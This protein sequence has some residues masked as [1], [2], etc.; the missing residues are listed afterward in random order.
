MATSITIGDMHVLARKRGGKCLSKS[1]VN[2]H[3]KLLWKCGKCSYEWRTTPN[4]IKNKGRWCPLCGIKRRADK[5]R[6]TIADMRKLA[7]ERGGKCLSKTYENWRTNLIWQCAEGHVW[8]AAPNNVRRG[9][10]CR[11]CSS[12]L[13][14]RICR[15]F[16]EQLFN[17]P[18]PAKRPTW[19]LN[20]RGNRMELDGYCEKAGIAFE[21]Q[22]EQHY[23]KVHTFTKTT[24]QLT[25]RQE[26]DL[27]KQQICT[28]KGIALFVIRQLFLRIQPSQLKAF[29]KE[30]CLR[31]QVPLPRGFDSVT[32]NYSRAYSTNRERRALNEL[33]ELARSR[34]GLL[35][36]HTYM[37]A[38]RK[39]RWKCGKCSY[40]WRATPNN[41]K[42]NGRWCPRCG[43]SQR[44]TITDMRDM[45]AKFGGTCLSKRYV[46]AHTKLNWKCKIK[47][48]PSFSASPASVQQ[49]HWCPTCGGSKPKTIKDM[50]ALA[51]ECN[52]RFLSKKYINMHA[53]YRWKCKDT[54]HPAFEFPATSVAEG[55]WCPL[56]S[57]RTPRTIENM[58][59]LAQEFNG[60]CLSRSYLG[61]NH[62]LSW[63]CG[64]CGLKWQ[65]LPSNV[66]AGHWCP[67]C[68]RKNAAYK[69]RKHTIEEMKIIAR[70]RGGEC[71]SSKY[72]PEGKL[73]WQCNDCGHVWS[74]LTNN[75]LRGSWCP[76]CSRSK[77]TT[78]G[79]HR[80][81]ATE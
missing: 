47:D 60:T 66:V 42:N 32:V 9:S 13:G 74:A 55:S 57:G 78:K 38:T 43:G 52:G 70:E 76:K 64:T 5:Q 59:E 61:M 51:R 15:E 24:K 62:K 2:A 41:I 34:G 30:E 67:K 10:W 28:Q 68:S 23:S 1:Y 27:R 17:Y 75:V 69:R 35:L 29:I 77:R 12:G 25:L 45:A 18:F 73:T 37:T 46:N 21:H 3:T 79:G 72:I 56:C 48:H 8:E 6:H 50:H 58:R 31:Q 4:N 7:K 36:S 16:F 81:R 53:S 49:G 14:E 39:L 26:D 65:S 33:Q 80:K 54:K 11:D 40:E 22:G 63:K 19:L 71:L 44:L 20:S